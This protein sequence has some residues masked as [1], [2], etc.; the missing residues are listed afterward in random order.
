MKPLLRRIFRPLL[1]AF[2]GDASAPSPAHYKPSH[3]LVL[4]IVGSLFLLLSLA[5]F[6]AAISAGVL[7]SLIPAVV[8]LAVGLVAVVIGTLGAD[9][10]VA[11]IWGNK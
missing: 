4:N 2:E 7:G 5:S 3:R 10:A 8:F 6:A 11:N 1:S 9:Q